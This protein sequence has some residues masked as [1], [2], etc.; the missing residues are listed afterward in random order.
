M[1]I[2]R[3]IFDFFCGDWRIFW[4]I[5]LTIILIK[6]AQSCALSNLVLVVILLL[7]ISL[8]LGISLK[9]EILK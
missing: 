3:K 7:G 1:N 6:L 2:L 9:R 5:T 8:S 4:G